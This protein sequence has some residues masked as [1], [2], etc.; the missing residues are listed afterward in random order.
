[1]HFIDPFF[2]D[3]SVAQRMKQLCFGVDPT[4]VKASGLALSIGLE[5][6]FK[7]INN[8]PVTNTVGAQILNAF[9]IRMVDGL[10]FLNGWPF[11]SNLCRSI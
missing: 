9:G 2:P 10:Q 8:K 4:P 3:F 11:F 7:V 1:M 6:R 5:D